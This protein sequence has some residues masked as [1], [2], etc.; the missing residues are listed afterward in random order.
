MNWCQAG[1]PERLSLK[2]HWRGFPRIFP[3]QYTASFSLPLRWHPAYHMCRRSPWMK[4]WVVSG[5]RRN[6]IWFMFFTNWMVGLIGWG[7]HSPSIVGK[8]KT[9]ILSQG[10]LGTSGHSGRGSMTKE[11]SQ[12]ASNGSCTPTNLLRCCSES[13]DSPLLPHTSSR[14]CLRAHLLSSTSSNPDVFP[15]QPWGG[16]PTELRLRESFPHPWGVDI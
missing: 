11:K 16:R 4:A 9:K 12:P 14:N 10:H 2:T 15:Q 8:G 1:V 5:Y 3:P 13:A 7:L 6:A